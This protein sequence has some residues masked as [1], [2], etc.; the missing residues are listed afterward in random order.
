MDQNGI[1]GFVFLIE[2]SILYL[3]DS[4]GNIYLINGEFEK[5]QE[6]RENHY[7]YLNNLFFIKQDN[8]YFIYDM[9]K[10]TTI[11][12]LE[13]KTFFKQFAIIKFI[14]LDQLNEEKDI[15]IK[16]I[17]NYAE[18]L[19]Q[20]KKKIQFIS[21]SRNDDS[22]YFLQN[23]QL[24]INN[25]K[26][27]Y[28]FF[29]YKGYI[30]SINYSL[31]ENNCNK[32]KC[33]EL[34]Y[35][36]KEINNLPQYVNV[37]NYIVRVFDKF[38][39]SNR[40]RFNIMNVKPDKKI[41]Y[42]NTNLSS[43]E[44]IY[45]MN[46]NNKIVKYGVFDIN[47]HKEEEL[48][49]YDFDPDI[50]SHLNNFYDEYQ[51]KTKKTQKATR[52]YYNIKRQIIEKVKKEDLYLKF[53]SLRYSKINNFNKMSLNNRYAF[54]FFKNYYFF[55]FLDYLKMRKAWNRFSE[56]SAL[57]D[58]L[59]LEKL[60]NYT[61]IRIITDFI[62]NI[63]IYDEIPEY[64]NINE[65]DKDDPY[66]LAI[67]FQRQLIKEI[68]ETSNIFYPILQFNSKILKILPDSLW[69]IFK[70]KI[71]SLFNK[72]IK[73]E[74]AYTISLENLEDMRTHLLSLQEDFFFIF[75]EDNTKDLLGKY[76]HAT[77]ITTIN[78]YLLCKDATT[79]YGLNTKKNYAF[80][81]N[82]VFSHERMGHAKEDL[83]NSA[84]ES[85]YTFFNKDFQKD[86]IFKEKTKYFVGESGRMFESF[87][88]NKCLIKFMKEE[89][90]FGEY[91][92]TKYFISDFK[93]INEK[94]I[95]EKKKTDRYM[96]AQYK[97]IFYLSFE[98]LLFSG[99]L[100]YFLIRFGGFKIAHTNLII[101]FILL[102]TLYLFIS[103]IKKNYN[104]YLEPYK[105]DELFNDTYIANDN[106]GREARLIY[107]D[108]YPFESETF[109][110]R[111][112]SFLQF[113]ENKIRRKF[114]R[115]SELSMKK[116]YDI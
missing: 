1:E 36:T 90:I 115:Y 37:S 39:C 105:Y 76:S 64:I 112:F 107:P 70:N 114:E 83:N 24:I 91:L 33:Y 22:T 65:L 63:F 103:F 92:E 106:E 9:N 69:D 89:K 110:G 95:S 23:F 27:I 43:L 58:E 100:I 80:S 8:N 85:P 34:I 26:N 25:K 11:N 94:A 44:I 93:E 32:N 17:S 78:H 4:I 38:N 12:L 50:E 66:R 3:I 15:Q 14:A 73:E 7:Y 59:E 51:N 86:Y 96:R 113:K 55:L 97:I 74:Y 18:K 42:Y 88:S 109:M 6:F 116:F 10:N 56:Y 53:K 81:I 84:N 5:I 71:K 57:L 101:V 41:Y 54:H 52:A 75:T 48:K 67:E 40:I 72:N 29:I 49:D 77:K 2:V 46:K 108:D 13:R 61:K 79:F 16:I 35:L 30:N 19:Y 62:H 31:E 102:L 60:D 45:L 21:L 98:I 104:K 111:Y 20:I 68:K 82:L 47:S 87:I 99:I 28:S